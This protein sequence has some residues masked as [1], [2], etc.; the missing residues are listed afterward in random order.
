MKKRA[1]VHVHEAET[2]KRRKV[3]ESVSK[4]LADYPAFLLV[5]A[6]AD[7]IDSL[8]DQKIKVEVQKKAHKIRLRAV[9]FDPS[10]IPTPPQKFMLRAAEIEEKSQ[11]WIVQVVGP[12]KPEWGEKIKELGGK[13]HGHIPDHALLVYMTPQI[14]EQVAELPFVEWV[15]L[16]EP[17]YKVSPL[18][19]G[20]KKRAAPDEMRTLSLS[21]EEFKPAPEGNITV[22]VHNPDDLEAICKEIEK[23]GG[24]VVST[25]KD[26][27][28]VSMDVSQIHKIAKKV[29]VKWIEPYTLPELFNDKACTIIGANV[30]WDTHGLDGEGQIVAVADTGLDTGVNDDSMHEDFRGRIVHLYSWK[31]P[32]ELRPYLKNTKWDDGPGD[33]DSGHGTHVTGSIL[34]DGTRSNGVIRGMAFKARV[35]FQAV[36]QYVEWKTY[37]KLLGHEDGYYLVGLPHNLSELFQQAYDAGARIHSN[38]WGDKQHGQYT[39]SARDIDEFVWNHK[40]MVILF[41][42]GNDGQD[43]NS[44]G[45][46]EGDSLG[47]QPCAKNCISVGA[48]EN[49]RLTGGYNPP[50]GRCGTYGS[51]WPE[52]FP[53]DPIKDDRV[54]DNPEGMAAFSSRGPT[55][56]GRIKPDVVAPGTNILSMRSS[57]A[58]EHGWGLLAPDDE[59]RPYYMFMGGTSMATPIA[60]GAV[61]L[62]RQYLVRNCSHEPSAALVKAVLIHGASPLTGQYNPP[63]VKGVPDCNQGWG[64]VDLKNSLFPDPPVKMEFKDDLSHAVGTG[65][66]K[67][68]TFTIAEGIPFKATLVW[69]DYP[70]DPETGGSL[71]NTLRLSVIPPD[72]TVVFGS[73]AN[74]NVQHITIHDPQPGVY[75]VQVQGLNVGT[76]VITGEKQDFALVVS[77]P[78]Q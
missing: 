6:D 67:E 73:P 68:F 63:E 74:N 57:Q 71:V 42:A 17:A 37:A 3:R 77:G 50:D 5:E 61:T 38:S 76:H 20:R 65:E 8:K 19:M 40:D 41:A 29:E 35:V 70:G 52:T 44:D 43:A 32:E 36:E 16:Y 53:V 24:T 59:R 18:L 30:I 72:D 23:L 34:G 14:K 26:T 69:T 22:M 1:L 64:R 55:D 31:I 21:T 62:I 4:V 54:S 58:T 48:S 10:E 27:I 66:H 51:C 49:E 7:Q 56:D 60:A 2:E 13:L 78:L 75:T 28:R 46:I 12:I 15:G 45:V 9:E 33:Y 39:L 47:S 25:G 11:Y